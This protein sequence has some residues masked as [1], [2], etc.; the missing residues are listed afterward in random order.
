M[1]AW[2]PNCKG[3]HQPKVCS[4]QACHSIN[5]TGVNGKDKHIH[6][7]RCD[8][9]S[10]IFAIVI[11]TY[12]RVGN[13]VADSPPQRQM[14]RHASEHCS[15]LKQS[16]LQGHPTLLPHH[17]HHCNM[18]S[19]CHQILTRSSLHIHVHEQLRGKALALTIELV[20][21]CQEGSY[22]GMHTACTEQ[23]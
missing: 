11:A 21:Q 3:G 22:A 23:D 18:Y 15:R 10:P 6:A 12:F 9:H 7:Y 16:I 17:L 19:L 8:S 14:K 1:Q 20:T 4:F 2:K 13:F 5:D